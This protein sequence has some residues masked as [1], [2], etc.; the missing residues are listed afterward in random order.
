MRL[1]AAGNRLVVHTF[2]WTLSRVFSNAPNLLCS[3]M[4]LPLAVLPSSRT[5]R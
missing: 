4:L 3:A 1:C 2:S 5:R